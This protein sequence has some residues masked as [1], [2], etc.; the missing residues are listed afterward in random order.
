M[1][2]TIFRAIASSARSLLHF[3]RALIIFFLLYAGMLGAVYLFFAGR[4][5]S[6]AQLLLNL[7]LALAAPVLFFVLQTMAVRFTHTQGHART[8]TIGAIRDFW[9]LL[10][11]SLPII[12][13]VGLLV[14]LLAQVKVG[15]EQTAVIPPPPRA[16]VVRAA[17]PLQWQSVAI[18]SIQYLLLCLVLPLSLIHLWIAAARD[19]LKSAIKGMVRS[20][21]RALAPG[22]V[23][24]YVIGFL[25]FAIFPY[26]LLFSKTPASSTWLDIGLLSGRLFLAVLISLVGWVV[27]LGALTQLTP[28]EMS[29]TGSVR[30]GAGTEHVP[31]GS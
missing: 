14:Y 13:L 18:A 19:G 17:P 7:L 2:K 15:P 4:E 3:W 5:T 12:A 29:D 8:L 23:L 6:S 31:V 25:F 22:S 21:G 10:L 27:T 24:I 11:I 1:I 20:L 26:F 30:A 28:D 9:K 16:T